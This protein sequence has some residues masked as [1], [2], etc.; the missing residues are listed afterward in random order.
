MNAIPNTMQVMEYFIILW[1]T[2]VRNDLQWLNWCE[3]RFAVTSP[4]F[5]WLFM[6]SQHSSKIFEKLKQF[7]STFSW[8]SKYNCIQYSSLCHNHIHYNQAHEAVHLALPLLLLPLFID[9]CWF[10]LLNKISS[11]E[12]LLLTITST[13][14]HAAKDYPVHSSFLVHLHHLHILLLKQCHQVTG[15]P[16]YILN[17]ESFTILLHIIYITALINVTYALLYS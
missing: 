3:Q 11:C 9:T 2:T 6:F 17:Y 16:H 4:C 8:S 10:F 7:C 14:K 1:E 12:D 15:T 13:C 5:F